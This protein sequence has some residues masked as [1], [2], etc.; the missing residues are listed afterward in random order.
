[1]NY[2]NYKI[3]LENKKIKLFEKLSLL[4]EN[5]KN[6]LK[7]QDDTPSDARKELVGILADIKKIIKNITEA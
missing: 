6:A 2:V 1:M 4:E 5:V 3:I 7:K